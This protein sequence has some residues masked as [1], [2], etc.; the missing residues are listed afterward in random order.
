MRRHA[1]AQSSA[2]Y[3]WYMPCLWGRVRRG[4]G[5]AAAA[6][7]AVPLQPGLL[8]VR[9]HPARAEVLPAARQLLLE[10]KA[11][12]KQTCML[13]TNRLEAARKKKKQNRKR[14]ET[15]EGLVSPSAVRQRTSSYSAPHA[16]ALSMGVGPAVQE[17]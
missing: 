14:A 9:G 1:R 15:E 3:E 13:R 7:S 8:L 10:Y 11:K 5:K 17:I 12:H 4:R 6:G 2:V 16:R